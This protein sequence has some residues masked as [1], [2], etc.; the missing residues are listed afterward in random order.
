M[1]HLYHVSASP[2]IRNGVTTEDIMRDVVIALLPAS[3]FSI[4]WFGF[5]SL[6]LQLVCVTACVLSEYIWRKC[7]KKA[8]VPYECSAIVT[9]I[10]LA[11]NLP[12]SIPVWMAVAGSVFA[13][14]V[15]KEL[16][17]GLGQNFMNPA[18][19]GRCF[20]LI[21][22]AGRMTAYDVTSFAASGTFPAAKGLYTFLNGA[23]SA[24]GISGATPL[25]VVKG[26]EAGASVAEK[27][28][29]FDMFFGFTG[30]VL[31]E[32]GAFM[33]LLGATYM[34]VRRVISLRIPFAYIGTFAVFILLFGGRGLDVNYLAAQ[35]FGGGL[36]LGAF[37]M[38]TD[39]VTGPVTKAGQV[40]FGVILGVLTGLFRIFGNSA[41]GVSYAIIFGNLLTPLIE[42]YT[43][44]RAFGKKGR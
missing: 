11:M 37:F 23:A 12:V 8:D 32:T 38:A 1:K 20:L 29:L 40:V 41:E 7:M 17:G 33:I 39:Y 21:C 10:L 43:M 28:S 18:L 3:L 24:D 14:I 22:F 25:A 34:V 6:L 9:G 27:V 19:A 44:P 42:K 26:L 31:G 13:I 35:L 2:H 4:Y 36:M 16:Y 30:G 15:V 5:R